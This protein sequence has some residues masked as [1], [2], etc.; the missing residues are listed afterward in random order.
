LTGSGSAPV[1]HFQLNIGSVNQSVNV[2]E[3][4]LAVNPEQMTPTV[5]ISRQEIQTTQGADL[6]NSFNMMTDF[7]PGAWMTHDQLHVRAIGGVPI[8]NTNNVSD[9]GRRSIRKIS[10]TLEAQ[11][12][13]YS[14]AYGDRSYG[15]FDVVPRTG[16]ERDKARELYTSFG[17]FAQTN[18]QMNFGSHPEKFAYFASVNE[19][20]ATMGLRP[21][22]R[23]FC[24]TAFGGWGNG[25]FHLQ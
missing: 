22:G 20:A 4:A 18:D 1:L 15:V 11:R 8:P 3:E 7:V 16:F 23:M 12:G 5:I 2:A 10:T 13:G 6:S 24:T 9:V 25:L 14:A 17:T 19:T 21:L